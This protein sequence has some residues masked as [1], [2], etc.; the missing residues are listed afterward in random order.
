MSKMINE[1]YKFIK[2]GVNFQTRYHGRHHRYDTS[3]NLMDIHGTLPVYLYIIDIQRCIG[4][5]KGK[6]T[7]KK[8]PLKSR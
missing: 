6:S 1:H 2:C 7:Q 4:E 5:K 8:R 3:W